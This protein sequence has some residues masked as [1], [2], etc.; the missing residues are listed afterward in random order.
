[1]K[2]QRIISQQILQNRIGQTLDV[3]IDDV[4]TDAIIGRSYADAPEIDGN[5]IY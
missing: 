2:R 4:N 3:L 5:Y 1:M